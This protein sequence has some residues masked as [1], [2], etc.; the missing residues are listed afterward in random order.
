MVGVVDTTLRDAHQS[1]I[2]TRFRTEDMVPIL[3]KLDRAGFY[4]LEVWGGATFDVAIR[5][6]KE[7][8]WE[9]LRT[10][11]EN[12]KKTKLQM[13]LRGQNLVG[14]RHYADDVVDKFVEL[15]YRN[16]IDIFRIFDALNDSRNL[17]ASIKKAKSVGAIVQGAICYTI[18]PI[19]TVDYYVK[20]AE[21]LVSLGVDMI[22]IK[23]MAGILDPYKAYTLVR[24]FKKRFN[25]PV[26]VH[27]H[28]TS[29]MA[30]A[31]YVKSVEAGA[32]L[33]DTA[34]SPLAFG[35]AQPGIQTVY[36]SLREDLRPSVDLK[37]VNEISEYL[38]NV[39]NQKYS[40]LLTIK[41]LIPDHNVLFHQ[42]PGGMITN[43]IAQLKELKAEHRLKEVLE[44]VP[45][46]REDLGWPPLVTPLS[47]IVGTQAALNVLLGKYKVI[48][49]EV[50]DYVAGYYGKPPGPINIEIKE[51]VLKNTKEI[52]V[53]PADLLEMELERCA[54]EV[55][56]IDVPFTD[57]NIVTYCLFP[58]VAREFFREYYGEYMK[59][60]RE[61]EVEAMISYSQ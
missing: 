53:R 25:I 18:S 58:D 2:A 55:R 45:K 15:A 10:I 30:V 3:E 13:L 40:K 4:S 61:L 11:R 37:V 57:E 42:I 19:H 7:D 21:E 44:E 26:D 39:I 47:Q 17:V 41:A 27:T 34:I 46:V 16:G 49:K 20:F 60:I 28:T 33:I 38:E 50:M 5:Y 59:K 6:L 51:R 1:L 22:T 24:E 9:R 12:V 36:F 31:T 52:T 32:D 29:G 23:D 54:E 43:L 8:P 48:A 14:Y 56:K 35:T